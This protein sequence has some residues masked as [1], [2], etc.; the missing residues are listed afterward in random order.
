[1]SNQTFSFKLKTDVKFGAGIT[2]NLGEIL[3]QN[4][5]EKVG[6]IVD[7]GVIKNEIYPDI[8]KNL[9]EHCEVLKIFENQVAEPDYDYLDGCKGEFLGLELDCLVGVG[10]GSTLDLAKGIATL[11]KNPGK[12]IEYRGSGLVKN[13]SI[14]IVAIPT[15]AGTGS[16]VT[17]SASFID[18]KEKVKL[19][20]TSDYNTPKLSILDPVL[21]LSCPKNVTISSGMDV[22]VHA[23]ESFVS[24]SATSI[25]KIFSREA[26]AL[27]FNNL[28]E[29]IDDPRS[30][31]L[32]SKLL[33][34]SYLA[35]V[36]IANAGGGPS[37]AM[38]YPLGVYHNVPHGLA[39]AV[40][41]PWVV[42]FNVE[43]NFMG[44]SSL[45]DSITGADTGLDEAK[46]NL[47]F[48]RLL[49]SL[50]DRLSIPKNLYQFNVFR[51]DVDFLVEKMFSTHLIGAIN[52][53]P[54]PFTKDD[55]KKILNA[56]T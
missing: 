15:T 28:A 53:N 31:E 33:I 25:S 49:I 8:I 38:S 51:E 24:K 10:G 17:S 32:R 23:V 40:F 34:S 37:A 55:A 9:K 18:K 19:G 3:R 29:V 56:M 22:M 7:I 42:K 11:L 21:T 47:E 50:C 16:E 48:S 4:G 2:K 44:Y 52:Q 27:A 41:L 30:I 45:Y 26:F 5:F 43:E 13:P 14:P 12:A 46:K 1:M 54:V 35:G 6:L 20:I 36:A 39:G